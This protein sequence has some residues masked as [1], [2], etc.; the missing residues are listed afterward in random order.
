M[1]WVATKAPTLKEQRETQT[2]GG[3]GGGKGERSTGGGS[4]FAI[5]EE[6]TDAL[7]IEGLKTEKNSTKSEN[8]RIYLSQIV[9]RKRSLGK[10]RALDKRTKLS[11]AKIPLRGGGDA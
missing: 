5:Q 1:D 8:S 11:K 7:K 2:R 3:E 4:W 10:V 6:R 9:V